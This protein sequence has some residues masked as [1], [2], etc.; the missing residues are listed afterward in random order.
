[1]E[2]RGRLISIKET[3]NRIILEI[4]FWSNTQMKDAQV[5]KVVRIKTE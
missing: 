4:A 2:S 3:Q 5:G 1:M